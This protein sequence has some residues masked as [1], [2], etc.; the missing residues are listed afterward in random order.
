MHW[1]CISSTSQLILSR[2]YPFSFVLFYISIFSARENCFFSPAY[3]C[4]LTKWTYWLNGLKLFMSILRDWF[5]RLRRC[6]EDHGSSY[7]RMM[8]VVVVV[9]VMMI[10]MMIMIIKSRTR[11]KIMMNKK[12]MM[13]VMTTM[14]VS[15]CWL[16]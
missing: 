1:W 2:L 16:W 5:K 11:I 13:M 3:F 15:G 6:F 8:F 10:I 14:K 4:Q 9:L 12:N 7:F